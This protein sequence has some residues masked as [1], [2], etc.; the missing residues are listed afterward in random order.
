MNKTPGHIII[1]QKCNKN[2]DHMPVPEIWRMTD[3]IFSFRFGLF[4][5]LYT[6]NRSKNQNFFL[7]KK[8][9]LGISSFYTRVPKIMI[10]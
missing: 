3:V 9:I 8:N 2:H 1:L 4:F 6:P 5:T 10:T 7:K